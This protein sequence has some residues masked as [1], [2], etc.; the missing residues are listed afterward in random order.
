MLSS[1]RCEYW[2]NDTVKYG[3]SVVTAPS[4]EPVTIQEVKDNAVIGIDDDDLL[5]A[6]KIT[7][8]RELAETFIKRAFISTT[9]RLTLDFMPSW[10]FYLP[11]PR[12]VSVTSVKNLDSAGV[13]Q[14]ISSSDYT[15]DTY[16]E[17]GR[18][19]PAYGETWPTGREH[20]NAIEVVYVAGY[21]S[22]AASVP[23]A[24]KDAIVMT[25][26]QWYEHRGDEGDKQT[27]QLPIAAKSL[28]R[29]HA[30]GYLP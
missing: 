23:Q 16:T 20:T 9:L 10:E 17:P 15:V 6:R 14:T 5:V 29:A 12:L 2:W 28:L 27:T 13:Q 26:T 24:I 1:S 8:A 25:V 3:L 22:T 11:R 19:T 4:V 18:I 21:G 30:W 7:A